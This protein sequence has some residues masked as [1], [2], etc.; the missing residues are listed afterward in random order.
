MSINDV[1]SKEEDF[2]SGNDI[3]GTMSEDVS[4]VCHNRVDL[5]KRIILHQT[6]EMCVY[7]AC[8]LSKKDAKAGWY[9][10]VPKE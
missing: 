5:P 7:I 1:S 4:F 2:Y 8:S 3:S 6:Q 9:S 10:P